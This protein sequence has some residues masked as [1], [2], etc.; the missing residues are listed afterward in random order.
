M[1]KKGKNDVST[2]IGLLKEVYGNNYLRIPKNITFKLEDNKKCTIIL[3]EE[4]VKNKNMQE[5]A[6]AFEGWAVA[7]HFAM[8][9]SQKYIGDKIILDIDQDVNKESHETRHWRRFLY[10]ALRFKQQYEWFTLSDNLDYATKKFDETLKKGKFVN[11]VANGTAGK[12]N[13]HNNENVIEVKLEE[14]GKL[15]D[16]IK[17]FDIGNDKVF[18]QLPVG[19]FKDE[20]KTENLFFPGGKSAIDLW[21]WN[22]DIFEVIE[23]KTLN[24]M[25]GIVTEIF[26]YANYMY[27][28]LV[29]S[30]KLFAVN[31]TTVNE[32][33]RGQEHI[34]RG[35]YKEVIG[36]MLA[37]K[38][39]P[40][41]DGK[42]L[43]DILNANGDVKIKYA[44]CSYEYE[45]KISG[46]E[47]N[48]N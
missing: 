14:K 19:L 39:H 18:R 36:I 15:R 12:K 21:T 5:N 10:R 41:I 38:Y 17:A 4:Y 45:L 11:N 28:L 27:D 7:I 31:D 16:V 24:P 9:T 20:V 46:I 25:I 34:R 47:E 37:D 29:N 8:K 2:A 35:L 22:E 48:N 40:L 32:V 23:L 26:F 33:D 6:N 43:L 30:E 3:K 1:S 42:F 44:K 13:N